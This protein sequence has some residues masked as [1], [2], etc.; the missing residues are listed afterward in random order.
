MIFF[1]IGFF[2]C[3]FFIQRKGLVPLY[4]YFFSE[5]K[6]EFLSITGL[7]EY[8]QKMDDNYMIYFKIKMLKTKMRK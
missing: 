2:W 5:L 3:S 1:E 8:L 6:V 4:F 7:T